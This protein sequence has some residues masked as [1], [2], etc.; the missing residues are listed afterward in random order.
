VCCRLGG[1]AY[2]GKASYYRCWTP[3][4]VPLSRL[5][6]I[7]VRRRRIEEDHQVATQ[8]T[9]LDAGQVVRWKSWHRWTA[10]CLSKFTGW[11][12]FCGRPVL[13]DAL[14]EARQALPQHAVPCR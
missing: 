2:T 3:D 11:G 5:I 1:T 6:A 14:D 10:I 12:G 4:P 9:G 8:G 7:V 13:A